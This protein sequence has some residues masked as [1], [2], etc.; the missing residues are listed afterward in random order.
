MAAPGRTR[1]AVGALMATGAVMVA[2]AV[3]GYL[4]LTS[5]P[6]VKAGH[7]DPHSR[8]AVS[9]TSRPLAPPA[10]L[11][12]NL[13]QISSYAANRR[14]ET[15]PPQPHTGL[16]VEIPALQISLPLHEG[17]GSDR[18]PQWQ[19]LHYPGTAAPGGQGNSYL[20]AHGLWGMFGGLLYARAGD[21]VDL[22]DYSTGSTRI[23]HVSRVV[24]RIA[25]NDTRW[26]H[27]VARQPTL[28]LQ[29]CVDDNLRGSRYIVQAT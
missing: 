2:V 15:R 19:A 7:P 6:A 28:T 23:L 1:L 27:A 17:D 11:A 12:A 10:E 24:G 22:R 26:I 16:W 29:T 3:A 8:A 4:Y 5:Q 9:A 21:E 13:T 18:V 20:Y 25:W 14:V